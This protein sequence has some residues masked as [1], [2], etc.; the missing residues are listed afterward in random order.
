MQGTA[1]I[2]AL[3]A[4]VALATA[5]MTVLAGG[6]LVTGLSGA[7]G[8]TLPVVLIYV[9]LVREENGDSGSDETRHSQ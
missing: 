8:L 7:V 3:V 6:R 9:V 2:V 5:V 1:R 4:L